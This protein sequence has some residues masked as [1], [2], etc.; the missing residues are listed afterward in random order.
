MFV[1]IVRVCEYT[2]AHRRRRR[3]CAGV[4]ACIHVQRVPSSSDTSLAR[5]YVNPAR[6]E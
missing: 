2:F 4:R 5:V 3:R 6:V 1:Y